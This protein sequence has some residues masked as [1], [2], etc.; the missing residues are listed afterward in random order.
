MKQCVNQCRTKS[1]PF[2][3]EIFFYYQTTNSKVIDKD[4]KWIIDEDEFKNIIKFKLDSSDRALKTYSNA[5]D[6][7]LDDAIIAQ[8]SN[9]YKKHYIDII[10][11]N[12]F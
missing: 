2:R 12:G 6:I 7:V 4:L 3:N 5:D 11:E 9:K 8:R 10:E 1:N